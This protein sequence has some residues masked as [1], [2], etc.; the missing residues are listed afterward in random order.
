MILRFAIVFAT[1][2]MPGTLRAQD[3]LQ[4]SAMQEAAV[5]S[6]PR[7]QQRELLSS[8]TELRQAVIGSDRLPRIAV[9][10]WASHQSDVTQPEFGVPGVTFPE[11]PKDR[12][13]STLDVEQPLYDAGDVSTRRAVERARRA[14]AQSYPL[15]PGQ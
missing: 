15:G 5:R 12:W 9:N 8:V 2:A 11:F 14:G 4:L 7:L 13:Q 1:L 6:D 3:T 10:G